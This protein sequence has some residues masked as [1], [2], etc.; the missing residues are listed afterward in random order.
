LIKKNL[1]DK[2]SLSSFSNKLNATYYEHLDR[3]VDEKNKLIQKITEQLGLAYL[4][5]DELVCERL[6]KI[7]FG[8]TPDGYKTFYDYGHWTLEG[9]KY[10]GE[11]I[12]Q[13]NW[14]EMNSI[15]EAIDSDE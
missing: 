1:S 13:S 15:S 5:K 3:Q 2:D 11:R 4:S 9:A 8:V 6:E 7:C 14:L 10:F 12:Y